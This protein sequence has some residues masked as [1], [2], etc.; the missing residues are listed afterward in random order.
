MRLHL[1]GCPNAPVNLDYSLDGFAAATFR[2]AQMMMSLGHEV[3]LYGAEGSN[4]PC[5]EL[6]EIISNRERMALLRGCKYQH[7]MFHLG[8]PLWQRSNA[9]IAAE[10]EYRKQPGDLLLT[11]GGESQAP[12]YQFH[13]DLV[14]V[15]YSVGYSGNFTKHRVFES[16]AWMHA[17]YGAQN[18]T[19]GRFFDTVIP[20][21]FDPSEFRFE[22]KPDD[23]FLYVGRIVPRKGIGIACQAATAA[24]VKLKVVGHAEED[25]MRL[26]TGGHEFLGMVDCQTRNELMSKARAIL[27]PTVYIEP[28][29]A[30][31]AE[32][33][34]CGTPVI[35][36]DFGAFTET[37][38]QGK[39]GFRCSYL[40]EF[41]KAMTDVEKLD[42]RYIRERAVAKFSMH[43]L[44]YDY[45]RY[46][47]RLRLLWTK[48]GWNNVEMTEGET[49]PTNRITSGACSSLLSDGPVHIGS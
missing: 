3:L 44:K 19:N 34:L 40:G 41:I 48:E 21:F 6:I 33:Q 11:I 7:A 1:L 25:P 13:P 38:E 14:G 24:R 43:V 12:I 39:T 30:S 47:E 27:V 22:E 18:I 20:L 26:I 10:I 16:Y 28:F 17:C 15:E 35:S 29:G 8:K 2:F 42:R 5:T 37:V 9:T 45:Q 23:Y 36:T 49:L 4:A 31:A 32:A 46:F